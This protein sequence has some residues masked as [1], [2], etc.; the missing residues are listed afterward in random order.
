MI[1]YEDVESWLKGCAM[2]PAIYKPLNALVAKK[3]TGNLTQHFKEK[4]SGLFCQGQLSLP[5]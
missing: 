3:I 5:I 4:I 2:P 1:S